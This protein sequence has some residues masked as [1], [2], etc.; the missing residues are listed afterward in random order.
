MN[1]LKLLRARE[2]ASADLRRELAGIDIANRVEAAD[3]IRARRREMLLDGLVGTALDPID[4]E[5]IDAERERDRAI[6][7]DEELRACIDEA[8]QREKIDELMRRKLDAERRSRE[9]ARVL[10]ERL[11]VLAAELIAIRD[12][13]R[14]TFS[15]CI[16][17]NEALVAIGST[18]R[19]K[20][21]T[22]QLDQAARHAE[23]VIERL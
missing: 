11:P 20:A 23:S 4:R 2:P 16:Q 15:E 22:A 17:V 1:L 6:A 3:A 12:A 7:F 13:H 19:V 18:D 9:T 10:E 8:E 5:L 14:A 21:T